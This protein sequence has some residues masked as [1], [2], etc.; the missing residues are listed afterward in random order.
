MFSLLLSSV[1]W[2][3]CTT[4][5]SRPSDFFFFLHHVSTLQCCGDLCN[6]SCREFFVKFRE[7]VKGWLPQL[8]A[9]C[10]SSSGYQIET[11][12]NRP[13]ILVF[14]S[15][16]STSINQRAAVRQ[17]QKR[18]QRLD[19]RKT[20]KTDPVC[21]MIHLLS[22]LCRAQAAADVRMKSRTAAKTR[23]LLW[24]RLAKLQL[25]KSLAR[26]C[27]SFN[28]HHTCLMIKQYCGGCARVNFWV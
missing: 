28:V 5:P 17:T 3:F 20:G 25:S 21:Q 26:K 13:H 24:L 12:V 23:A 11:S 9:D 16:C 14:S 15:C 8:Q 18:E 10:F 4:A 7:T 27:F 6:E 19:G 2:R 22:Q 1:P